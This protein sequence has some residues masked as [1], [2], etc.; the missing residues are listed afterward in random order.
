[1]LD[2]LLNNDVIAAIVAFIL[3]L[4]PAVI[5]HELG[6]FVAAKSVGITILEFGIG[7]PPRMLKLGTWRGTEITLNWLPLGGFVRPLG[8]DIV[9]QMG[10]EAVEA[11][12]DQ[13]TARGIQKTMSV[14]EAP[15][16]ARIWFMSA[17]AIF[18]F[19]MA[20]VLFTIIALIGLPE[21]VGGRATLF[22]V[23]PDSA[24]SEAGLR[25]GDVIETIDGAFFADTEA[26]AQQLNTLEQD[27]VELT[28]RREN[29]PESLT[30]VMAVPELS[31]EASTHPLIAGVASNSPAEQAGIEAGDLVIAFNEQPIASYEQLQAQTRENL[32]SEVSLTL[33]RG[34]EQVTVVLT[35]RQSPPAGEGAMGIQIRSGGVANDFGI[36]FFEDL[37]QVQLIPQSF[38]AA[39][40]YG[41]DRL[42]QTINQILSLPAQLLSG[43]ADPASLRLTSPL[44]I[45]QVGALFLQNSIENDQPTIILEYM[46]LISFALGLTNLLPIPALDGGRILF[47]IV[48]IIRGKPIAPEREGMV[49]LVGLVVLLSLMVFVLINDIQN[50]LVDAI[51]ALR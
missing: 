49:H 27:E 20:V 28:I 6:H 26:L 14:N 29:E 11:D 13:A 43:T 25:E 42:G 21:V 37:P 48:E 9:R 35:P 4:I 44:G 7:M 3:V 38:G 22:Y 23:A 8:E 5:V 15:P 18:N 41:F 16:L 34:S 46:A 39:V 24:A 36:V 10:D 1:M 47:V 51:Q 31:Q 2:F 19:V 30:I 33:Q 40:A 12:R 50:P 17:G 45:S 32:G